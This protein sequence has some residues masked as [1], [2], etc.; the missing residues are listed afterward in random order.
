MRYDEVLS[1]PIRLFWSMEK[2]INKVRAEKDLRDLHLY[3]VSNASG[4]YVEDLIKRLRDELGDVFKVKGP[5]IVK[6]EPD[7]RSKLLTLTQGGKGG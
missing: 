7:A 5:F 3:S 2:N 4:D 6:P 1:M